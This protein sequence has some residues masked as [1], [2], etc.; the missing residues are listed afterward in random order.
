M[1]CKTSFLYCWTNAFVQCPWS[2]FNT[3]QEINITHK[4][5]EIM[6]VFPRR[7][8]SKVWGVGFGKPHSD[9]EWRENKSWSWLVVWLRRGRSGNTYFLSDVRTGNPYD[10]IPTQETLSTRIQS[11]PVKTTPVRNNMCTSVQIIQILQKCKFL[12]NV[13]SVNNFVHHCT[14]DKGSTQP[15]KLLLLLLKIVIVVENCY[16]KFWTLCHMISLR[17]LCEL[18]GICGLFV[19]GHGYVKSSWWI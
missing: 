3:S 13:Y 4:S 8:D 1:P 6:Q 14:K 15:S 2:V 18:W 19:M 17:K 7:P 16:W 11:T 12:W 10:Q 9:S 5:S